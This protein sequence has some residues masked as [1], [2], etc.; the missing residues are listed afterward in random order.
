MEGAAELCPDWYPDLFLVEWGEDNSVA[1]QVTQRL[2]PVETHPPDE[3]QPTNPLPSKHS[4]TMAIV[5]D[6][7]VEKAPGLLGQGW[8]RVLLPPHHPQILLE[9]LYA[10]VFHQEPDARPSR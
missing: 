9:Q 7:L 1:E 5:P 3:A 6:S 4:L 10:Q 8:D 2:R